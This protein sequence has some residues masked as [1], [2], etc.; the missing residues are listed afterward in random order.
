MSN[1]ED[2]I[3][4]LK[5]DINVCKEGVEG[6]YINVTM[7]LSKEKVN[8]RKAI[9][10]LESVLKMIEQD[11]SQTTNDEGMGEKELE[12]IK[13]QALII[14]SGLD[15]TDKRCADKILKSIT[16]IKGKKK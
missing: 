4:I 3:K 14:Q 15:N 5:E 2:A 8:N 9:P 10:Q 7:G 6:G 12:N 13:T 11:V 1:Y 16:K